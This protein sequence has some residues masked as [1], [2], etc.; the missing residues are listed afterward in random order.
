MPDKGP[1]DPGGLF[2]RPVDD[3]WLE[4][5]F[6]GGEHLAWQAK[7]RPAVGLIGAEP[8]VDG[9]ARLLALLEADRLDNVR[10]LRGDVRPLLDVLAPRSLGRVFVLFPDPWPK[11]RHHKRRIVSPPVLDRLAV[12]MKPGAE[13][14][15]AT[16]HPDYLCWILRHVRAHPAFAWRVTGPDDW[17]R[18]PAD[19]PG[20]RYE[21]KAADE[22][23]ISTYLTFLRCED[24]HEAALAGRR[25]RH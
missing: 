25:A 6:G 2:A 5:G 12:L 14:R 18:R 1:L 3:V 10:I 8:F 22:G 24:S 21:A 20:T 15:I 19:W 9:V 17:R 23:R 13:L 7:A 16:D 11:V 4:I